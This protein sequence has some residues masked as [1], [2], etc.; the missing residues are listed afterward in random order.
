MV[1]PT[2]YRMNNVL[3]FSHLSSSCILL[4][5]LFSLG[6]WLALVLF[7]AGDGW[8]LSCF[9]S[10]SSSF[11]SRPSSFIDSMPPGV[12]HVNDLDTN[13]KDWPM[14]KPIGCS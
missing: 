1:G 8:A 9:F 7:Y 4:L 3:C 11:L 2:I 12:N 6:D 10:S 13:I 14:P 5:L